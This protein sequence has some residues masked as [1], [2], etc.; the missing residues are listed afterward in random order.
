MYTPASYWPDV[1]VWETW[2]GDRRGRW[3]DWRKSRRGVADC[4][5]AGPGTA[6]AGHDAS[7]SHLGRTCWQTRGV[8]GQ[9]E[10]QKG[11]QNNTF[12]EIQTQK[13]SKGR[14]FIMTRTHNMQSSTNFNAGLLIPAT[15]IRLKYPLHVN[16]IA[17]LLSII[18]FFFFFFTWNSYLK[19]IAWG[20]KIK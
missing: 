18:P 12:L 20:T 2:P 11:S 19:R 3:E 16:L 6:P 13:S 14:L 4:W 15:S 5:C 17:Q 10:E 9:V 8:R 1:E 7:I